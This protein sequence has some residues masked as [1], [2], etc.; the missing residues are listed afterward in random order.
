MTMDKAKQERLEAAGWQ[1]GDA[2]QFLTDERACLE[3]EVIDK[4]KL[5]AAAILKGAYAQIKADDELRDALN[6]LETFEANQK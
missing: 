5:W 1:V 2:E 3:R 6:A 4:A